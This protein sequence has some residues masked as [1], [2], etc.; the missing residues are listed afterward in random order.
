MWG[1]KDHAVRGGGHGMWD[2]LWNRGFCTPHP[3]TN[4]RNALTHS[5]LTLFTLINYISLLH[6]IYMNICCPLEHE[7]N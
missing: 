4:I 6:T 1:F 2:N 7:T 3:W 5:V